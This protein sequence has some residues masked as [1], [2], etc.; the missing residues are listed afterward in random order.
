M[1]DKIKALA[2]YRSLIGCLLASFI[3]V[4]CVT[5]PPYQQLS[6]A[7]Q[8][9]DNV[10][11]LSTTGK[12]KAINQDNYKKALAAYQRAEHAMA[13]QAYGQAQFDAKTS[14]NLSQAIL[15]AKNTAQPAP[16]NNIKFRH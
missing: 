15:K 12:L 14:L 16:S 6:E 7:K 11:Q 5:P 3:L 13:Q 8:A 2:L 4:S 9:L 1:K 10:E